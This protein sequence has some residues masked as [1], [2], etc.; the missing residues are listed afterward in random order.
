[1]VVIYPLDKLIHPYPPVVLGLFLKI[2]SSSYWSQ[3]AVFLSH[4]CVQDQTI[5]G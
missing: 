1:M 5:K 3:K 2:P 4:V